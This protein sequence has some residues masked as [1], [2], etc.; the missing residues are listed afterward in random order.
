M[1]ANRETKSPVAELRLHLSCF[2]K[3]NLTLLSL[4]SCLRPALYST[5][6]RVCVDGVHLCPFFL[7]LT[8]RGW[9]QPVSCCEGGN[10]QRADLAQ[11]MLTQSLSICL[12]A[13]VSATGHDCRN[14]LARS[15][16]QLPALLQM[17]YNIIYCRPHSCNYQ[18]IAAPA[19]LFWMCL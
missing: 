4:L 15:F 3:L 12:S 11:K 17:N 5:L 2:L 7:W 19:S 16:N 9:G 6:V 8:Y 18:H 13:G 10:R 14:A 1:V